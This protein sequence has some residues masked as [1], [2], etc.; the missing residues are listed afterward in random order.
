MGEHDLYSDNDGASPEDIPLAK[1]KIHED[2][3]PVQFTNDIAIL[4]MERKP[5]NGKRHTDL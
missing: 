4:T 2:Y 3:S 5:R 1:K